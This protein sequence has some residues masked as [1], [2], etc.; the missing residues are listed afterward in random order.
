MTDDVS[1]RNYLSQA[2]HQTMMSY[3]VE[4]FLEARLLGETVSPEI[5]SPEIMSP[6]IMSPEMMSSEIML[7]KTSFH[8]IINEVN[9]KQDKKDL[10]DVWFA[11]K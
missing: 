10:I 9:Y 5:M 1:A 11:G 8:K 2:L 3:K 4:K 6:E 7:L